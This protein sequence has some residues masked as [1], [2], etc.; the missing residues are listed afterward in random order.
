MK[1]RIL[2][3]AVAA[4][5]ALIVGCGGG[6]TPGGGQESEGSDATKNAKAV[7]PASADSAKGDVNWCI[8]KDT[9]GTFGPAVEKFNKENPGLKAKLSELPEAADEQRTQLVQRQRA[10][11]PECDVLGLDV[12]W[13]AEF[14]AQGWIS[15]LTD[16]LGEREDEFIA[17]TVD[18]ARYADKLWAYPYNTNAGFLYYRTDKGGKPA[19]T[20][21]DVYKIAGEEKGIVYQGAP[22]EGLTVNFLEL[23]Y[24]SGGKVLSDDGKTV[25]VGSPEAKEVMK[26]MAEGVE[27]GAAPK[28]VTTYKEE[29][30][31]R[32]FEAGKA[33]YMRN[34]PYAYSLANEADLKGKF[35]ITNFPAFGE[36]E[37]AGVLGGYN[38]AI[39]AF[40]ENPGGALKLIDFLTSLEE[41]NIRQIEGSTPATVAA[42]YDDA[43]V[44]K[45]IPFAA[46]LKKAVEQAQ[47]RPVSPVYPLISE[48]IFK[49]TH[50]ALTGEQ[51][52]DA[53]VDKMASEIEKAIATF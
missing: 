6:E 20:W 43:K 41:Q 52:P 45:A 16:A 2:I 49:N 26:F 9:S 29:E 53:A 11:S 23:L 47:P 12:I 51:E 7:D 15:D 38:L 39:S 27:S 1:S 37:G 17:S 33:T 40:S 25:E 4:L 19:E 30:A 22:Y 46:D 24:S 3:L 50:D 10:K 36:G 34:W 21:E 18:S 35:E 14:A 31:R 48:A 44:K 8:G 42:S 32:S 28:A 13:T 5:T